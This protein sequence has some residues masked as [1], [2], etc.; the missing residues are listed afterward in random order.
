MK[1]LLRNLDL[2]YR[3]SKPP[4]P[5]ILVGVIGAVLPLMVAAT[6]IKARVSKS[7]NPRI[8]L[9]QDMDVQ[10][11]LDAQQATGVFADGRAMRP[12]VR[13]TVARG[14]LRNDDHLY[15]GFALNE[16]GKPIMTGEGDD[17]QPAYYAGYPEQIEVTPALLERGQWAFETFCLTCH[18]SAGQGNGPTHLRA[19]QLA[20][21]DGR[22]AS[23]A[24][25]TVWVQPA[26]L[27]LPT[28]Y[29]QAYPN[30]HLFSTIS[31]GKGNMRGL[32]SQI[33]PGDRWA[34]VAY[35][36]ALQLA[37]DAEQVMTND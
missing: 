23:K 22:N 9:W 26:N 21:Y 18:G 14:Q 6:I 37:A 12:R 16:A 2:S 35:I 28:Y 1:R 36:R 31:H 15:R 20:E 10:P 5:L 33:E 4:F 8:H 30:G 17:A 11:R 27:L 25:G 19:N 24:T 3:I 32:A 13:G 29:A 7:E 34:I